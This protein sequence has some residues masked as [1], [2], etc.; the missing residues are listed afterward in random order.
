M[1][2]SPLPHGWGL[3]T[4]RAQIVRIIPMVRAGKYA[5]DI[6]D[7]WEQ[8]LTSFCSL[9]DRIVLHSNA[10]WERSNALK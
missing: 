1:F 6:R 5:F 4:G 3:H 9:I 2:F 8:F 7:I 10:G